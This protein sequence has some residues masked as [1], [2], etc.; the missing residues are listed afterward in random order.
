MENEETLPNF[1]IF[2]P[3]FGPSKRNPR[4]LLV[5]L[6]GGEIF[7]VFISDF[8]QIFSPFFEDFSPRLSSCRSDCFLPSQ[9]TRNCSLRRKAFR[10]CLSH[11]QVPSAPEPSRWK[12]AFVLNSVSFQSFNMSAIPRRKIP[13]IFEA[14]V[15]DL[16]EF[17]A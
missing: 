3:H 12:T 1:G 15:T 14:S 11:F 17:H 6:P 5:L 10:K 13:F 8:L 4:K 16:H 9:Q 7:D 2:S